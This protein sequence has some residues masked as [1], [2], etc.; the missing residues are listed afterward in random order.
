[1]KD[2]LARIR[3]VEGRGEV[4]GGL[5]MCRVNSG[6]FGV[7]WGRSEG[8]LRG[9]VVEEGERGVVEVWER[10]GEDG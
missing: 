10:E 4:L 6:R 5:R 3:E 2:L 7:E 8:I 1:M 9:V